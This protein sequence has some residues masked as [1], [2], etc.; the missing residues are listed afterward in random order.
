MKCPD[1]VKILEY[2]DGGLSEKERRRIESHIRTCGKCKA[3]LDF[4]EEIKASRNKIHRPIQSHETGCPDQETLCAF[5]EGTLSTEETTALKSHFMYCDNCMSDVINLKTALYNLESGLKRTPDNFIEKVRLW[6][7]EEKASIKSKILSFFPTRSEWRFIEAF[8]AVFICCLVAVIIFYDFQDEPPVEE[9]SMDKTVVESP[10]QLTHLAKRV[11]NDEVI[12]YEKDIETSPELIDLLF[13]MDTT[14][15]F[16]SEGNIVQLIKEKDELFPN[17]LVST[18]SLSREL[19][20]NIKEMEI[21]R[22]STY[23]A[24]R[25]EKIRVAVSNGGKLSISPGNE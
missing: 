6:N 12:M 18:I 9:V 8:A 10:V 15:D 14:T 25:L 11:Q 2:L 22:D 5:A 13:A 20:A 21:I 19:S 16:S 23:L 7:T 1:K 3:I 4:I 17:E 24:S